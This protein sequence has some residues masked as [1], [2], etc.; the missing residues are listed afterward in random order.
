M[1]NEISENERIIQKYGI[2]DEW[3]EVNEY[4]GN[5]VLQEVNDGTCEI[6]RIRVRKGPL[7]CNCGNPIILSECFIRYLDWNEEKKKY[8]YI[9][10]VKNSEQSSDIH[11][12]C[13]DCDY[14]DYGFFTD[15]NLKG[16]LLNDYQNSLRRLNVAIAK[17]DM[18]TL[19]DMTRKPYFTKGEK[20]PIWELIKNNT[21]IGA[22]CH[23]NESPYC[24]HTNSSCQFKDHVFEWGCI[25][26]FGAFDD[27]LLEDL[28]EHCGKPVGRE[29]ITINGKS[30]CTDCIGLFIEDPIDFVDFE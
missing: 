8:E 21:L 4:G 24:E 26:P 12:Q 27:V 13:F 19:Y 10:N 6:S 30:G 25:I 29:T 22:E 16:Y 11:S 28:C 17:C 3:K 20:C 2:I 23:S 15:E 5:W 18:K 1:S 9:E 14:D 7:C